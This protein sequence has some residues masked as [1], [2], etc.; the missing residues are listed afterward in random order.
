MIRVLRELNVQPMAIDQPIDLDIPESIVMIAVY[1]SIPEAEN[2]RPGL[3]YF[4]HLGTNHRSPTKLPQPIRAH[5]KGQAR[6]RHLLSIIIAAIRDK[7]GN[8]LLSGWT[9]RGI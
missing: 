8:R 6:I 9:T 2:S 1:L 4:E 5:A 3:K 7:H